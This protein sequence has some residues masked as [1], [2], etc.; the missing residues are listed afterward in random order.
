[1]DKMKVIFIF[2]GIVLMLGALTNFLQSKFPLDILYA[3]IGMM[4]VIH[5]F[6][7]K[8]EKI[9]ETVPYFVA[10]FGVNLS[11]WFILLYTFF[12][13]QIIAT[14]AILTWAIVPVM[15]IYLIYRIHK[16]DLKYLE[17][18]QKTK[19]MLSADKM[20][21][22]WIFT[23]IVI[24]LTF[25]AGFIQSKYLLDLFCSSV[26]VMIIIYGFHRENKKIKVSPPNYSPGM[27]RNFIYRDVK[28]VKVTTTY[29][30]AMLFLF[31]FQWL[32][33]VYML[34]IYPAYVP[35]EVFLAEVEYVSWA[36]T[37]VIFATIFFF[38]QIHESHLIKITWQAIY[39]D[40]KKIF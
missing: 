4:A 10:I 33:L 17:N 21:W 16:S 12:N 13:N 30:V 29:F 22:V 25:L 39:I 15:T 23:G 40:N 11:Q 7:F 5:G 37:F 26:G 31:I 24:M 28:K 2:A 3:S 35:K 18:S 32:I 20:K 27:S 9:N 1:M 34:F 38:I 6:S 8:G 19:K 36:F 14:N